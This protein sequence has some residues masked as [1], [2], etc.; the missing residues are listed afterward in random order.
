MDTQV[1]M[2]KNRGD[3]VCRF[4]LVW[5]SWFYFQKTRAFIE[6]DNPSEKNV[7][8]EEG[9]DRVDIDD[10]GNLED[11]LRLL[12]IDEECENL[13]V[14]NDGWELTRNINQKKKS[15]NIQLDAHYLTNAV[16]ES[17]SPITMWNIVNQ[18]GK[19]DFSCVWVVNNLKDRIF[20]FIKWVEIALT[21][22]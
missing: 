22:F 17:I 20:F 14:V 3:H 12:F 1:C 7:I 16:G 11:S 6:E 19:H 10:V 2:K 13:I 4:W 15:D 9:L 8:V 18:L 21:Q 5:F